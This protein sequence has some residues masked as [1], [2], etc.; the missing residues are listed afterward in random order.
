MFQMYLM[1][2]FKIC[3]PHKLAIINKLSSY[4]F[5]MSHINVLKLHCPYCLIYLKTENVVFFV[6][7]YPLIFILYKLKLAYSSTFCISSF[8]FL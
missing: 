5:S 1:K 8:S 4:F 6:F 2:T 3:I 7:Y